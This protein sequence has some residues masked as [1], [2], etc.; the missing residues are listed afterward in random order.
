MVRRL[1]AF[2]AVIALVGGGSLIGHA[3]AYRLV[4]GTAARQHTHEYLSGVPTVLALLLGFSLAV[5][6]IAVRNSDAHLRTPA[7]IFAV[8]PPFAFAAQEHLERALRGEP[9]ARTTLEATFAVGLVLQLPFALLAYLA[10][11]ILFRALEIVARLLVLHAARPRFVQPAR[12]VVRVSFP[13]P[14]ALARGFSSRGP[15]AHG[16]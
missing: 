12:P 10:A 7:W 5:L 11:R 4:E 6:A 15:P 3:L 1:A 14:A 9:T 8:A 16:L 13:P 2:F